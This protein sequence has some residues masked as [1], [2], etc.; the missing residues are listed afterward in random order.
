MGVARLASA[1]SS[2]VNFENP[3]IH[4]LDITPDRARLLAV[5]TADNRLEVFAISEKGLEHECSIPVGMEPV[6]VRARTNDEAWVANHLSDSVSIVDLNTRNVVNSLNTGDEP[7]DVIFAGSPQRA[8]VSVSQRNQI[9]VYDANNLSLAPTTITVQGE[10]PRA[11]ATDGDR[12][13]AAIFESGNRTTILRHQ[14]VS[15]PNGPYGGQNPPPNSGTQFSPSIDGNLPPPPPVGLIVRRH[16]DGTWRDDNGADWSSKV[17]WNLHD[18]DVAVIDANSLAVS[19][20]TGLMNLN[21]GLA[22]HP[23]TGRVMVVGTEALNHIRFEQNLNG[24]FLRVN[25]ASFDPLDLQADP[26]VVD[27]NP[28]LDYTTSNAPQ[29]VRDQSIGD[30]RGIAWSASGTRGYI[31]GMGS[32]NLIVIDANGARLNRV[33]LGQGP[34]G[35]ALDEAHQRLYVYNRFDSTISILDTQSE[36]VIDEVSIFDPTPSVVKLGRPLLYDTHLTSGLGHVACA[37]CH[38][39]GRMDQLAWDLGD[40][41]GEMKPVAVCFPGFPPPP[42]NGP[43]PP[44]HPMKGPMVTQSLVRLT[45]NAELHW[46]GDRANLSE[47]DLAFTGLQG[48]DAPPSPAEM[49]QFEAFLEE[50]RLP[51]NPMLGPFPPLNPTS[52]EGFLGNPSAGITKFVGLQSVGSSRSCA[53]CHDTGGGSGPVVKGQFLGQP[54]SLKIPKLLNLHEFTGFDSTSQSSNRGFGF[55]HDGSDDT[56]ITFFNKPVFTISP[57]DKLDLEALLMTLSPGNTR[58]M[59]FQLTFDG[60][61]NNDPSATETLGKMQAN[62][63]GALS[64]I[65]K[66]LINGEQRGYSFSGNGNLQSDRNSQTTTV[67]ALVQSAHRGGEITFTMVP[68]PSRVRMGIDRDEDGYFDRDELDAGT[69]PADP[70]DPPALAGDVTKNGVVDVDDLL[71]VINAWGQCEEREPCPAD[72]MPIG[73]GDGVVDVDDLLMVINNWS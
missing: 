69:N 30:P 27:L 34:T 7:A 36:S 70:N 43:C 71:A 14:V 8:F 68:T 22:V 49:S 52:V 48:D 23:S 56:L 59:G 61:N 73:G 31:T 24:V 3:H 63:G 18:H 29:S 35:L 60:T 50:I 4:P 17:T 40:P 55:L 32:N 12:V 65:A 58:S 44:F 41:Q 66:G 16:D 25:L 51:P 42:F 10:D 21:M 54:Q 67:T 64:L 46:R 13:Y 53:F 57:Q 38:L 9:E 33:E 39:D 37:S 45:Q 28:H 19:Y 11:L 20:M 47:F 2:F 6:A 5:N 62:T 15:E 72:I 1:Q 26:E